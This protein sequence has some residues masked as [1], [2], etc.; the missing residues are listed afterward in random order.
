MPFPCECRAKGLGAAG[1][2]SGA[3]IEVTGIEGR[4]DNAQSA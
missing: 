2:E 1:N 4:G 3:S